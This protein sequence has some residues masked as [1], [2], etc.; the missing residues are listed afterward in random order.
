MHFIHRGNRLAE[1][2][3]DLRCQLEAEIHALGA[4]VK[5]QIAGGSDGMT[6]AGLDFPKRMQFRRPG[7]T[8]QPVPCVGSNPHRARQVSLN[9]AEADGT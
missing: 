7:S 2:G 6:G 1:P 9:I 8:K 3:H 5:Q 4:D